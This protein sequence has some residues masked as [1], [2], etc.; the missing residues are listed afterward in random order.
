MD[1][2][3]LPPELE[4]EIFEIAALADPKTIPILVQVAHRV[5]DWT[6]PL[7]YR[8]LRVKYSKRLDAFLVAL[9]TKSPSALGVTSV[10]TTNS[11]S[12]PPAFKALGTLRNLRRMAVSLCEIFPWDEGRLESEDVTVDPMTASPALAHITHLSLHDNMDCTY[13][14][15]SAALPCI[16]CL[17]H[18]RLKMPGLPAETVITILSSRRPC[19]E[20]LLLTTGFPSSSVNVTD[21][22]PIDVR[23]VWGLA[24][25]SYSEFWD[26]WERGSRGLDDMWTA[27]EEAVQR[28]KRDPSSHRPTEIEWIATPKDVGSEDESG[29][30]V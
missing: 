14:L 9:R 15:V 26:D 5:L 8:T 6:E 4:R 11:F 13:H 25:D 18:L 28:R 16:P 2:P 3:R 17:T 29:E 21:G 19:L 12:G 24:H 30:W 27:A 20:V 7:L 1:D 23:L 22:Y 10:G